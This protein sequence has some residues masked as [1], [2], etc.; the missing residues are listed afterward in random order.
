MAGAVVF[1]FGA[2]RRY[3]MS[4][5]TANGNELLKHVDLALKINDP[6]LQIG[7]CHPEA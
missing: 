6:G 2:T 7:E 5:R 4:H 3:G 1:G